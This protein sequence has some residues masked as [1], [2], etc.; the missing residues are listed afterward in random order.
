MKHPLTGIGSLLG[1]RVDDVTGTEPRYNDAVDTLHMSPMWRWIDGLLTAQK[2]TMYLWPFA[3][4]A[5]FVARWYPDIPLWPS[6]TFM[7]VDLVGRLLVAGLT[8]FSAWSQVTPTTSIQSGIVGGEGEY[9]EVQ[10]FRP[11]PSWDF[12]SAEQVVVPSE[13]LAHLQIHAQFT[14]RDVKVAQ[15]LKQKANAWCQKTQMTQ[16]ETAAVIPVAVAAA[17]AMSPAERAAHNYMGGCIVNRSIWAANR[18]TTSGRLVG[19]Q[20]IPHH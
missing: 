12:A 3:S 8:H 2:F 6:C 4:G 14:S 10:P 18:F 5:V 1:R 13:L 9:V 16:A 15:E 11:T 7:C 20:A 19:G 17:M